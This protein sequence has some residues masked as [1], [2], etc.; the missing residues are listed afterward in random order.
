M[1]EYLEYNGRRYNTLTKEEVL[2]FRELKENKQAPYFSSYKTEVI[3]WEE[4]YR[5]IILYGTGSSR[6]L[7]AQE[8]TTDQEMLDNFQ[9]YEIK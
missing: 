6:L 8:G 2:M 5:F 4:G 1:K 7:K 9:E 3:Q